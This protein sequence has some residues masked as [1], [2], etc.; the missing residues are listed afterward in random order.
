MVLEGGH[1]HSELNDQMGI[2]QPLFDS[3]KLGL[4]HNQY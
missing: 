2:S 3:V 4:R 1:F